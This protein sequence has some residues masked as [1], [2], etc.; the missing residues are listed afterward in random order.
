MII[1]R[2]TSGYICTFYFEYIFIF[3]IYNTVTVW[4]SREMIQTAYYTLKCLL[5]LRT[6]FGN[7]I[8]LWTSELKV[9]LCY[10]IPVSKDQHTTLESSWGEMMRRIT[11]TPTK[12]TA[13]RTQSLPSDG[14]RRW[15]HGTFQGNVS[16]WTE[17]VEEC[18]QDDYSPW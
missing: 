11:S 15:Y 17:K 16:F 5:P 13:D 14:G 7:R 8:L 18:I 4:L 2:H 1:W 3:V 6:L 9:F 12:S 10:A